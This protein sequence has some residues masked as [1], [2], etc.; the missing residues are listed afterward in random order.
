MDSIFE[1]WADWFDVNITQWFSKAKIPLPLLVI[2]HGQ[3]KY[4]N[5]FWGGYYFLCGDGD[6]IF[7]PLCTAGD[8]LSHELGR[9]LSG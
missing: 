5:A 2:P 4:D 6:K 3:A 7:Y 1:M 9:S 8:V